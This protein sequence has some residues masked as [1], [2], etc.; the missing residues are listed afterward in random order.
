MS[1]IIAR[2]VRDFKRK[3]GRA[4]VTI[5]QG[6]N[7]TNF[8]SDLQDEGAGDRDIKE[9]FVELVKICLENNVTLPR[10]GYMDLVQFAAGKGLLKKFRRE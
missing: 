8:V 3:S 6:C 9:L 4:L 10:E 7:T 1:P 2:Y 5:V